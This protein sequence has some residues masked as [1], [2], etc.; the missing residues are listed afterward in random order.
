M[1][2]KLEAATLLPSGAVSARCSEAGRS[3]AHQ[4]ICHRGG[5]GAH[6]TEGR[7]GFSFIGLRHWGGT[8]VSVVTSLG[9]GPA[10]Q[11]PT[12]L[13]TGPVFP[14]L[15]PGAGPASSLG[16]CL[17][18]TRGIVEAG[19]EF[20]RP[21]LGAGP[22]FQGY[23]PGRGRRVAARVSRCGVG[24]AGRGPRL[25]PRR[26]GRVSQHRPPGAVWV[27]G[28][29]CRSCGAD[30]EP[31]LSRA[32]S[33]PPREPQAPPDASASGECWRPCGVTGQEVRVCALAAGETP[34]GELLAGAASTRR[35]PPPPT[36][37]GQCGQAGASGS[38][39]VGA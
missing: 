15:R 39:A 16:A 19:P 1:V 23:V 30:V 25:N 21:R 29:R 33:P 37:S 26:R 14:G 6:V 2:A 32:S 5:S 20:L 7:A 11:G 22:R 31:P 24:R 34:S 8:C 13:G 38:A 12:T 35:A 4:E 17:E 27:R 10:F 36:R 28:R 18:Y 3:Q 9:A